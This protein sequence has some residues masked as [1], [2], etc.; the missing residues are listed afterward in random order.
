[1]YNNK[2]VNFDP[3]HALPGSKLFAMIYV[4]S[5]MCYTCIEL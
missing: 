2:S 5:V 1:M 3:G 4:T